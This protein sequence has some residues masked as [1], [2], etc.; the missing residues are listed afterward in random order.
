MKFIKEQLFFILC[1]LLI[2][3]IFLLDVVRILPSLSMIGITLLGLFYWF[4]KKEPIFSPKTK[5]FLI[6]TLCFW[7]LLP[8][9]FYSDNLNYFN[10]KIQIALP[11]LLLPLAFIKIPVLSRL[12]YV[13][14]LAFFLVGTFVISLAAFINYLANQES[15]NQ[16]Y[17]ESKVMPTLVSHHPTFSMMIVFAIYVSYYLSQEKEK[18]F[19]KNEKIAFLVMG[20]FLLVFIHIFSVRSGLLGLYLLFFIEILKLIF[21]R[22]Q[23]KLAIYIG[24]SLLLIGATTMYF[25]PTVSNKIANT[26]ADLN[27]INENKSA[28]NQSLSSRFISYKNALEINLQS[29]FWIGCG[30]GDIEDLN[31]SIFQNKYPD[32][33]K[34]IIPHNQFLY[35]FA[36][37]GFIGLCIFTIGFFGPWLLYKAYLDSILFTHLLLSLV[38]FLVES[39]LITQIG[40]AYLL[41][42]LLIGLHQQLTKQS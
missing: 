33:S 24:G 23:F 5:P 2:A 37:I 8:S 25:S 3:G 18:I 34:P 21:K 28:N 15:I 14:L 41:S 30:L 16:L 19:I 7:V 6:L 17:L 42:F 40:V 9:Y 11:F 29:N 13:R 27:A 26:S 36:A 38:Y 10:Q 39:P 22:K 1:L 20:L 31:N 32:V 4:Q 12:Q 35:Y